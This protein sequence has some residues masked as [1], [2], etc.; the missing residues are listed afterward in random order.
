M[1][2]ENLKKILVGKTPEDIIELLD[3]KS[4]PVD[5]KTILRDQLD[6]K[7][8]EKL[9]WDRLALDGCVY[10]KNGYPEIWL[11][12]SVSEVRQNF[13]LAHE[14]GHIVNDIIPSIESYKDPIKDDYDT[15]YRRGTNI[16][17]RKANDFAARFLMPADFIHQ[18]ARSLT[19]SKD[20]EK[21]NLNEVIKRMA[22]RF[23]V[24]YD[25]MKWRLVNLGYVDK[26][27][28]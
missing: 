19:E 9:E 2:L 26:S 25:A 7:I 10:L 4:V 8:D 15:L 11:N 17:E 16:M 14:L 6:I 12:N 23:R 13:T 27:K 22:N 18:E 5:I 1:K 3:V 21:I 20:F 28:V 24:S